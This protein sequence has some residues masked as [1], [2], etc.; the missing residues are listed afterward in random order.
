LTPRSGAAQ[1]RDDSMPGFALRM[2]SRAF[3]RLAAN[4][5]VLAV[6]AQA[7]MPAVHL[8][9]DKGGLPGVVAWCDSSP[10]LRQQ[11][12]ASA[13]EQRHDAAACPVCRTT[14]RLKSLV[15]I[16]RVEFVPLTVATRLGRDESTPLRT[17]DLAADL[18]AR[19]PPSLA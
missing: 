1:I 11:A 7:W 16:A 14:T 8:A 4:V 9:H 6:A 17:Q 12:P 13:P 15:S 3:R 19:A 5:C 2:R 10:M 18:S